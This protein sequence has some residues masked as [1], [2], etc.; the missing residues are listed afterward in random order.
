MAASK[1]TSHDQLATVA[2]P[3]SAEIIHN[4]LL[5]TVRE[6]I[7]IT[8]RAA[9][10]T[11]FSEAVDFSCALFDDQGRLVAQAGGN[12]VH[13]GGL[14]DEVAIIL[15]KA[16]DLHEGDVILHNDP[17]EGACHQSDVVLAMPL[18]WNAELVGLSVNRGHWM[19]IGGMFAGGYGLAAHVVQ[20]GLIIPVCKLYRAGELNA[21]LQEFILKNVRMPRLIWG[22]IQAQIASARAAADRVRELVN[23]YGLDQV[24]AAVTHS[25]DYANRRFRDHMASI[26]D[27]TYQAEDAMDDDG[28]GGGP[29]RIN[30]TVHKSA[31][32]IIVDFGGT[33]PQTKGAANLTMGATKAAT[34]TALKAIIDPEVPFN[35]GILDLIEVRAPAGTVVN[36]LYPAPVCCAPGDPAARVCETVI[37][38]FVNAVPDRVRGGTYSTGLNSTGWGFNNGSEFMWYVFGPGGCGACESHDGLTAEWHTMGSCANESIEIWEARYPVR[39]LK[40]ELRTD[41]GGPGRTRGGLGDHRVLEVLAETQLTAIVDRFASQPWAVQGGLPGA[42]NAFAV[43]REG[44]ERTFPELYGVPSAGKFSN[45]VLRFGDRFVVK[46]GG[47]GGYGPPE[48][49]DPGLVAWDVKNGYVTEEAAREVYRVALRPDGTV[50]QEGMAVLRRAR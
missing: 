17:F 44:V 25:L 48:Q 47:G 34:F 12:P 37:K 40:R 28:F 38:C 39:V 21:G 2:D 18:F 41:S 6:M 36:P 35:S 33:D 26:P 22:D 30:V 1:S 45:L 27:G 50:D 16:E 23:R 11:C 43:E 14:E 46:A 24:R 10:S 42:S 13:Y 8:R 32:K 5:S 29:F 20:E 19:D 7:N 31:D 9:Y 3:F 4:Y 15:E 49:R